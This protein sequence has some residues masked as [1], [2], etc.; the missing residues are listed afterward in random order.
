MLESH[1][2]VQQVAAIA[3]RASARQL[4]LT[5]L[6]HPGKGQIGAARWK[7][8]AKQGYDGEVIVGQ[9]LQKTKLV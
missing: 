7:S 3:Q 4:V 2:K 6:G 8:R 5:H 9:D 1:V